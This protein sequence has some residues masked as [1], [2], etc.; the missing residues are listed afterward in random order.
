MK[1]LCF[2]HV[3]MT[4]HLILFF[5]FRITFFPHYGIHVHVSGMRSVKQKYDKSGLWTLEIDVFN[6]FDQYFKP[7][8]TCT[9]KVYIIICFT[10]CNIHLFAKA[11]ITLWVFIK[12]S[13]QNSHKLCSN[14][15]VKKVTFV[16]CLLKFNLFLKP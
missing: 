7:Q 10:L 5:A 8:T 6:A 13:K 15:K 16:S 2:V 11:R 3:C 4:F 1:S 9:V 14:F 12:N